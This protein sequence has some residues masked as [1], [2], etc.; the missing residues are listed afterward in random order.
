MKY[1]RHLQSE[2]HFAGGFMQENTFQFKA[3]LAQKRLWLHE[4]LEQQSAI[5]HITT[6]LVL[7]GKLDIPALQ[8][9]ISDM[10]DRHESFRTDF[11]YQDGTLYQRCHESVSLPLV[12]VDLSML[13]EEQQKQR[14][15]RDS[16][17]PF[18]LQQ[19][20]L[21]R[22]TLYHCGDEHG[23]G[24][25][26]HYLVM[27]LHHIISDGWS[28]GIISR[29][30]TA[31]YNARRQG[32]V[33]EL[34]QL[35]IQYI[36]Y[37]EWQHQQHENSEF[38]TS[39]AWWKE[40]LSGVEPIALPFDYPRPNR[41]SLRGKTHCFT[42]SPALTKALAQQAQ[43]QNKTLFSTLLS[44]FYLL[45]YRYSGQT[46]L[47]VGSPVS[48]RGQ[49]ELEGVV[50]FFV[51]TLAYRIE[52]EPHATFA[53]LQQQVFDTVLDGLSHQQVSFEQLVEAINPKRDLSYSPLFQV[54][55]AFD[56]SDSAGW[57]FDGMK[58]TP[59]TLLGDYAKFDLTLSMEKVSMA[60]GAERLQ[61]A[62]EYSSDLFDEATIRQFEAN[63]HFLLQ[64]IARNAQTALTDYQCIN[65]AEKHWLLH[66]WPRQLSHHPVTQTLHQAF[67]QQV[68]RRPQ[69][70]ALSA[71]H[72]RMLTYEQ[73]NQRA[74]Q[75]AHYILQ[76]RRQIE[77]TTELTP[78]VGL[79]LE[80]DEEMLVAIL[81]VLKAGLAYLPIDGSHAPERVRFYV[82][83]ARVQLVIGI[84]QYR[85][86]FD[87]EKVDYLCIDTEKTFIQT[88]S[89]ANPDV[90]CQPD[91]LAYVIYTSGSTGKPKGVEIPHAN[92]M[93]LFSASER[94]FTFTENDVWTLFHSCA[95]DFS[96]WEIWGALLYGGRLSIVP[97]WV[98]RTPGHFYQ[99]VQQEKVTV[100]NQTPSAFLLFI[101][102]DDQLSEAKK[103][104]MEP[105]LSLRYV[106]L[107]GEAL[108]PAN[109]LGWFKK[110]GDE[111]PEII[112]MYGITETTVHVTYRRIMQADALQ[113][114]KSPIGEAL[115]DL[116]IFLLD[117]QGKLS[118]L[119]AVGEMY[120]G[121]A[122][123]ARGYLNRPE[124]TAQ[125]FIDKRQIFPQAE[126]GQ[127]LYRSGDLARLRRDGSLEYL[128][129]AD[130]QVKIRGFRIE[131]GEIETALKRI[132]A[133]EQAVVMAH[134]YESNQAS[135][136][137]AYIVPASQ[138]SH[139][140]SAETLSV[141]T[142]RAELKRTL[143]DYMLP[144][145]F[146]FL[147][148]LP[149]TS[150]GKIDR[151]A[152][153]APQQVR[154]QLASEYQEARNETETELL[155]L[156]QE[157]LPVSQIGIHDNFFALGGDSLRGVQLT[158]KAQDHGWPL[159]LVDLFQH[160]TIAE[161]AALIDERGENEPD[162]EHPQPVQRIA[163]FSQI[164][165]KD[166]QR[167]WQNREK[168]IDAYP[169]SRMQAGMFYHMNMSPDA[170][171]YH[172]TGT[173]HLRV[174]GRFDEQAFRE[175]T[176][177]TVAAHDVLR[178]AF[179]M[180]NYSEPLQLV[181]KVAEL[182]IV[183]EDLRHLSEEEQDERAKALLE[184]ERVNPFDLLNPTLL[185]FFIQ[186][187]TDNSFQFTMTECHPVFDGWSY[188]TMIVEVFNRYATLT[189]QANWQAPD[190]KSLEYRD[191]IALEQAAI[192][193]EKQKDYWAQ[194]LDDCT[195]LELPRKQHTDGMND[196]TASATS[197]KLKSF[198]LILDSTVYQG[199]RHLMQQLGVPL[200]S[201][202]L[203]GH[204]K[205]MSIFSG[206]HDILTG[207]TANGRPEAQGGDH[208]YG[209][210]LNIL[211]FRQIL[212]PVSWHELIRQVFA[213]EIEAIP[214]R[215]YPLAEIQ[216]QFGQQPLLDE[217][218]FNYI[219]FHIYDQMVPEVGLE[220]VDR[221]HTQDVYE[222]T[223]FTLDVHFQHLTLSS[224][225]ASDQ[226]SV[227]LD[228]D[229][230]KI[231]RGLAANMAECYAA[232][233]AAMVADPQAL[234]CASHFLPIIQQ[235]KIESFNQG[236]PGYQG[237]ET[238]AALFAEQA[239]RTPSACAVEYGERQL[240]YLELHQQSNQLAH[241][242]AQKGVKQGQY[243]ALLLGRSIELVISMLAL[244]K[245]GAVY[246][247]LNTE[248]PDI[249]LIEQIED[250]QCD[251]LIIDRRITDRLLPSVAPHLPPILWLDEEQSAL[252]QMPVTDL[253]DNLS[254]H[255]ENQA[256]L[257][258]YVMYTSGSTGKPKGVLIGQKGI[259]RLVKDVSY[260]DF[261]TF[262]RCLQLASVSFDAS[263]WEIWGPLLN[264][265]SIVIYPQGAISVLLLE[266]IIKESGVESLFLTSSLFNLI[267]D[268]RPQT[269]QTVKQLISGGEAMSSWH[270]ARIK[271]RYP[272][273]LL[274]NGYGPTENTTFTTSHGYR[275]TEGNSV[276]IGKPNEGNL[277]YIL[278]TFHQPVPIGTAGEL[279]IGGDG[280]AMTYLHQESL[281]QDLFIENPFDKSLSARLYKTGDRGRYLPNGDIEYL[282]RIDNQNKIRG[283]R[284]ETGEI[285]AVLCKHPDVERAVVRVIEE[286]RGKRIAAYIVL[287]AGQ[288]LNTMELRSYL[289][290]RLPRYMIPAYFRALSSL[291]LNANGKIDIARL[292][293]HDVSN[294]GGTPLT[295]TTTAISTATISTTTIATTD[296]ATTHATTTEAVA[297]EAV[298]EESI[299]WE[300]SSD[301]T[302]QAIQQV[303]AEVLDMEFPDCDENF[304][305]LGGDSLLLARVHL[306]LHALGY[307]R[308]SIIDLLNY[309]TIHQLAQFINGGREQDE[310]SI[311]S[312]AM[313]TGQKN[314]EVSQSNIADGRQRLAEM[315]KKMQQKQAKE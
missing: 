79:C 200:K 56:G 179:D 173:S 45:L 220:V 112:N 277:V 38:D 154:P 268:E 272:E 139:I 115:D 118:L 225:L 119:G 182:P 160:Q 171:V 164:S 156:W 148:A 126:A 247:P 218:L 46:D 4:Q 132:D 108:E 210:F 281:Y 163:P 170:N 44:A 291:P 242:L 104:D 54:M 315:Q 13:S 103:N 107:G 295:A 15:Q 87:H 228:Y 88:M 82:E 75:L 152:L 259:I 14:L 300:L 311:S 114:G 215:R 212:T 23:H 159:T 49:L 275:A 301:P 120:V 22:F 177:Q 251:L 36:D 256:N 244:V 305:D 27:V 221:L 28:A 89:L 175:A 271:E 257:P 172:C 187:R 121:G 167:L 98:S 5:Y 140:P 287:C 60:D 297:A 52:L 83:D 197:P 91:A 144:S 128:G 195:I 99:W 224:A 298:E 283:Y 142:I 280:L 288:T 101:T 299:Q 136:L 183:V 279:Y 314:N 191:F 73:L 266:K 68:L 123:V 240:S 209:L 42:L 294:N 58:A 158:G 78:L 185:R 201:I 100:L 233:F 198:S 161:L 176:A 208:L 238:L 243:V 31:C 1:A 150:N 157:T 18:N 190:K 35:P 203:T 21:L 263:T 249:R 122:G 76:I 130:H 267:V 25:D 66:E 67:E 57:Q 302:V 6:A 95:F 141:E 85:T 264:G 90:P 63:F 276:P 273:L 105:S 113:G 43:Q 227:Q 41:L 70:I 94:H 61:G 310:H 261:Q 165:E 286:N 69:A 72:G 37:S 50:G 40:K 262:G 214:Y 230:N 124:L 9:A 81:A 138:S 30:L 241:L 289:A 246:L 258:A 254:H 270:A 192:A 217:V 269:L 184:A 11:V 278:D 96:V 155:M 307:N 24:E 178:T 202:L 232:V 133:I 153:P 253:P 39:L 169:L 265:G 252:A 111:K 199:L 131:L 237:Q 129:R 284:V 250:T 147:D 235:R 239:A 146:I 309:S 16:Q 48:G 304:F 74:N 223:H 306:K 308:L 213:N 59:F 47:V 248:D 211:P 219:D 290:E 32:N 194:K 62:F 222:G 174:N 34:P 193:D 51:N 166:R 77:A 12:T 236:A 293:H 313:N 135:H 206:E 19:A 116:E 231:S 125:R 110:H 234:H 255:A 8:Q 149:L 282:G 109:L 207:I 186:L 102:A 64:E 134:Q 151:K 145:A 127:R 303:W 168:I 229:E 84:P 143:P 53:E 65:D 80:R 292:P 29:E 55:F 92:V 205:V 180:E 117:K 17:Q 245:L 3:S 10:V 137:V 274:I 260:I 7:E 189:G 226:I 106:I 285:E 188:N 20:P 296:V 2:G 312:S 33:P 196:V 162:K 86:L 204:I 181:Y 93:R 97:Y 216:R 71:D 26:R